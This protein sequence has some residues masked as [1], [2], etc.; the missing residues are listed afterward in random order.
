MVSPDDWDGAQAAGLPLWRQVFQKMVRITGKLRSI[1][2]QLDAAEPSGPR[3]SA[4]GAP[5]RADLTLD[6][7]DEAIAK[8]T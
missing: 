2:Q 6:N 7:L 1:E 8:E 5:R 3:S 4:S